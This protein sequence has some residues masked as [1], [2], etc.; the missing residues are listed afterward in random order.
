MLESVVLALAGGALGA[1]VSYAAFNGFHTAT[2][3][4]QSFSQ[5]TFSLSVTRK[6]LVEGVVWATVIGA[7]GGLLPALRAARQPIAVALREL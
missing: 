4:F 3:N 2:M 6:L 1:A 5:V 7:V